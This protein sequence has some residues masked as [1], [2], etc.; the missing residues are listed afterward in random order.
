MPA[1]THCERENERR[2]R[3]T[4]RG[5]VGKERDEKGERDGESWTTTAAAAAGRAT[6]TEQTEE[7]RA[8]TPHRGS[9]GFDTFT[10]NYIITTVTA[11]DAAVR[12]LRI[13][14]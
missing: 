3:G 6:S 9:V 11:T 2:L 4:E 10:E 12:I 7:K 1:Y 13:S 5:R 8:T 14:R